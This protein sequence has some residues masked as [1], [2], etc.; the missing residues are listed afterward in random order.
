MRRVITMLA[1][2][3]CSVAP[4][5]Y[6]ASS[7]VVGFDGGDSGGFSGNAVFEATGGNPGGAARHITD[8][9]FNDLVYSK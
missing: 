6:A 2:V 4:N 7:T 1:A 5:A 3:L 9:F 8:L